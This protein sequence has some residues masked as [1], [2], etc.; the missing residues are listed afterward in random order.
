[1]K[2]TFFENENGMSIDMIPETPEEVAMLFRVTN[3]ARAEKPSISLYLSGKEP[4]CSIWL[5]KISKEK[6]INN[7][8]NR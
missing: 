8:S 5:R 1:M 6:Q 4:S 2:M 7:V 3:N